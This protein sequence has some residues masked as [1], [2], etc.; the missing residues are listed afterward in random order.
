VIQVFCK[1]C[2]CFTEKCWSIYALCNAQHGVLSWEC[3][4]R[5]GIQCKH[6]LQAKVQ[7]I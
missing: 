5:S 4:K 3:F 7:N 2:I 1:V 6:P